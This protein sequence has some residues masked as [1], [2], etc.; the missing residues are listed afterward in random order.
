MRT[1]LVIS[2]SVSRYLIEFLKTYFK[3]HQTEKCIWN[4]NYKITIIYLTNNKIHTKLKK[5]NGHSLPLWVFLFASQSFCLSDLS[6]DSSVLC[7]KF[8][9]EKVKLQSETL[10]HQA[11][12]FLSA[13]PRTELS[14]SGLLDSV[15]VLGG[16][17]IYLRLLL[18]GVSEGKN[19][20]HVTGYQTVFCLW[21]FSGGLLQWRWTACWSSTHC[22]SLP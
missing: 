17:L 6:V 12:L 4:K 13:H 8:S 14:W 7:S 3:N 16:P 18:L 21:C 10:T 1:G 11:F 19:R 20:G 9:N 22:T 2:K 5:W 15:R